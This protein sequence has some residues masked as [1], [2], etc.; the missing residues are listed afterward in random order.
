[1]YQGRIIDNPGIRFWK[2]E[3]MGFILWPRVDGETEKAFKQKSD[4]VGDLC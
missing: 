4:F 3:V 2:T 1:M